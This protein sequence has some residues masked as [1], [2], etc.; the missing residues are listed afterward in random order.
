[1]TEIEYILRVRRCSMDFQ[2][3]YEVIKQSGML[4]WHDYLFGSL[5]LLLMCD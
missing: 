1:M 4:K 3:L 2:R 5:A